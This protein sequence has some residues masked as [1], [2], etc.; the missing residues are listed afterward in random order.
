MPLDPPGELSRTEVGGRTI[1][2]R[3]K[4]SGPPLVLLHGFI[5][6]SRIWRPQL[7]ALAE[8]FTVIAWDAPGA[9]ASDDPPPDFGI[10]DWA[11]AL[12]G[13]LAALSI[14]RAHVVGLSWGGLLAQEL[15]RRSPSS[16]GSLVL[17]DSYAGWSGSLGERVAEER[18]AAALRDAE[19]TPDEFSARYLPGMLSA[20]AP[21]AARD[22]MADLIR[23]WHPLGFR[24]MSRAVASAD[25]RS[26]LEAIRV[27]TL[28]I[29][30]DADARSPL[31]VGQDFHRRIPG[32]QLVVLAGAGH[33]S[34][35]EQP[36][37]FN[38]A[39]RGFCE[40]VDLG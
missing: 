39:V 22:A 19:L 8:R 37:A 25:T 10:A 29:W 2:Y 5:V 38:A 16:V 17:A 31:S 23:S 26:L 24:L 15:Y 1:A 4:G 40:A 36:D 9:G 30:G 12:A 20:E 32:S 11:D 3:R 21:G 27:P 13:F 33:V 35:L 6:D 7:D 14:E 34:N 28:L 18:L